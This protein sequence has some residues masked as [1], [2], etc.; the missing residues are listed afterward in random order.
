MPDIYE[1]IP[2]NPNDGLI[3]GLYPP[4]QVCTIK[5]RKESS[6]AATLKRGTLLDLS[7]GTGGDAA[8]VIHGTSAGSNETLTPGMILAE[9]ITVGTTADAVAFAYR[10]G[11]FVEQ[12][13]IVASGGSISAADKETLRGKQILLSDQINYTAL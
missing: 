13:L 2:V 10:T 12:K 1:V 11:H 4:A 5:I 8:Y 7:S 3:A 6:A 9:D